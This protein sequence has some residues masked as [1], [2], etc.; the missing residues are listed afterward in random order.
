[1]NDDEDLALIDEDLPIVRSIGGE[2]SSVS[3]NCSLRTDTYLKDEDNA[4]GWQHEAQNE[5]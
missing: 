5:P 4:R 3:H 1:M 2:M